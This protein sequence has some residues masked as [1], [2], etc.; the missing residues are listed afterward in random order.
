[1]LKEEA[2]NSKPWLPTAGLEKGEPKESSERRG[3]RQE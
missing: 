1:M 3:L 2:I